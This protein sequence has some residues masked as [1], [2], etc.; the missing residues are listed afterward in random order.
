M[1]GADGHGDHVA[2]VLLD[3]DPDVGQLLLDAI[4]VGVW[5]VDLVDGHD[6][7]HAGRSH[8]VDRL[9]GLRH[10]PVIR[11]DNDDRDVGDLGTARAHGGEGLLTGCVE[12]D[13][14][15]A[16][17][18]YLAGTD[19]LRDAT[20]L[21]GGDPGAPHGVEQARLA[22]VDVPHDRDDRGAGHEVR[23]RILAEQDRL[24]GTLPFCTGG[25]DLL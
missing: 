25:H 10:H 16:V 4:R 21:A 15:A 5:L 9:S 14:P 7:R 6:H 12:E 2:S 18:L 22:M 1:L 19:V 23:G 20:G 24:A 17:V 8:V 13:D 3:Q 11:R